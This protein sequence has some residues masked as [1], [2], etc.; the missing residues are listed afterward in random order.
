MRHGPS[1][2]HFFVDDLSLLDI[3]AIGL[4]AET[5]PLFPA[6]TNV[7]FVQAINRRHIRRRVWE[8]GGGIALGAG[9]CSCGAAGIWCLA[10][11]AEFV[12]FSVLIYW[13]LQRDL[14]ISLKPQILHWGTGF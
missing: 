12:L 4:T 8:R 1:A 2:L 11:A 13:Q 9:T 7:H 3:A 14:Q 5:N 10:L 6:K